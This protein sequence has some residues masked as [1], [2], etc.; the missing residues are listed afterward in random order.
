MKEIKFIV[1]GIVIA[2][3]MSVSGTPDIFAQEE[4]DSVYTNSSLLELLNQVADTPEE[5]ADDEDY[6]TLIFDREDDGPN[7]PDGYYDDEEIEGIEIAEDLE[8]LLQLGDSLGMAKHVYPEWWDDPSKLQ[9][10]TTLDV[11]SM[12]MPEWMN[13]PVVFNRYSV[14]LPMRAYSSFRGYKPHFMKDTL[15]VEPDLEPYGGRRNQN[16]S[17]NTAPVKQPSSPAKTGYVAPGLKTAINPAPY[18]GIDS[19][20]APEHK[21]D[22]ELLGITG[23]EVFGH[24]HPHNLVGTPGGPRYAPLGLVPAEGYVWDLEEIDPAP[25]AAGRDDWATRAVERDSRWR[26]FLQDWMLQ[27]PWLVKYNAATMERPPREFVMAVDPATEKITVREI[28]SSAKSLKES[29]KVATDLSRINWIKTLDGSLQF[30]QAYLSPNWYQGGNSNVNAL[31]NVIYNVRL[32][33]AFHP[34]L[35]FET[36]ISYKL[37]LNN[38]PDDSVHKYNISDD[39]L[40]LNSKFGF[41]AFRRW[42][43]SMNV[44]F[45]TQLLNNYAKN[46][47]NMKASFMSPGEL[48]IGV[49]MTYAYNN[50]KNTFSF[51]ASI[52][53]LSYNLKTCINNKMNVTQ[54]GIEEGRKTVS[55]YGSSTEF[56]WRWK[57]AYNIEYNS[58]LFFF[59]NY[60]YAQGDWEHTVNFTLSRF[61]TA[62]IYA[63]LRYDSTMKEQP[64]TRWR[65][66]Q[67]KEIF[68]LGFAYRFIRN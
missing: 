24:E 6:D 17:A 57:M 54:F 58:R 19:V 3:L 33:Q 59:T 50:K 41:K 66:W 67:F 4:P 49:G 11:S 9:A 45:K 12:A 60:E 40:Q 36:T 38:A 23:E 30:S 55:K 15:E 27:Y 8:K 29:T 42:Y 62:K 64:D 22:L 2:C 43:Y 34:D 1:Y 7:I 52:A 44:M 28:D 48:N 16:G 13:L 53:P 51:N 37:G 25:D 20:P 5:D 63:H 35:I 21:P 61:L 14:T 65:Y 10:D 18:F 32:N 46:S 68:S 39:I 31:A 47:N 56:T 26:L